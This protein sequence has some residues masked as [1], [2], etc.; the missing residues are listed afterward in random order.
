MNP[1][2][3]LMKLILI[4]S[5]ILIAGIVIYA[6]NKLPVNEFTKKTITIILTILSAAWIVDTF[7][8]PDIITN[9]LENISP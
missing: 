9:W 3:Q 7:I 5:A 6:F 1:E 8:A 4:I 2:A